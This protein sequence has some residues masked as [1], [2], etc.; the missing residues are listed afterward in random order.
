MESELAGA[1]GGNSPSEVL[2]ALCPGL[3]SCRPFVTRLGNLFNARRIKTSA[4]KYEKNQAQKAPRTPQFNP[5]LKDVLS[6]LLKFTERL[7]RAG[8]A[9][10]AHTNLKKVFHGPFP[11]LGDFPLPAGHPN[12]FGNKAI[13]EGEPLLLITF[14]YRLLTILITIACLPIRQPGAGI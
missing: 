14:K 10:R 13:L 9:S 3:L 1:E 2:G 8:G 11:P 12:I 7:A 6:L 5:E 4:M